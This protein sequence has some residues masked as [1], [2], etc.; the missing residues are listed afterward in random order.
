MP[1]GTPC[2]WSATIG[3]WEKVSGGK[4]S[5]CTLLSSVQLRDAEDHHGYF[6][7]KASAIVVRLTLNINKMHP[8]LLLWWIGI[9]SA[10]QLKSLDG[11]CAQGWRCKRQQQCRPFQDLR[12]RLKM[13]KDVYAQGRDESVRVQY[14]N[15]LEEAKELVCNKA[16]KGVCCKESFEVVNGNVVQKVEDVP[17]MA[18]ISIKTGFASYASCGASLISS[19]FLLTAKHCLTAFDDECIA[20]KDCVAH[21]RDLKTGR[22]NHEPGQFFI[23]ITK[24]FYKE[25]IGSDLAVIKL[26]NKVEEHP[27]YSNGAALSPIRLATENPNIGDKCLTAGWGLTGYNEE[28]SVE[29]RSLEL[30]VTSAVD[31]WVYTSNFDDEGR[32]TDTCK[33]DSGGPLAIWRDGVWELV[34]VL[35]GEGYDCR[36]NTTN[37]DGQWS[38]VAVQRTWVFNQIYGRA[39]G[40]IHLRGTTG[41][42]RPVGA[43]IAKGNVYID[44]QPI[45]D[46]G[47]GQEEAE[48]ACRML[49]YANGIPEKASTYG[50][51]NRDE[52]FWRSDLQCMGD[53]ESL[54][55]CPGRDNPSCAP[56]EVAG[57]TCGNNILLSFVRHHL[58]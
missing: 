38:S 17:Y 25:G 45:C 11:L 2:G 29:L 55:G 57:V 50:R 54:A 22:T 56:G 1:S 10:Q 51:A 27:E 30:K 14:E 41:Q 36:T 35:K 49:G 3:L 7:N 21:F 33:G 24:V 26:K 6:P 20:E 9:L 43:D 44:D 48:V 42:Q 40:E 13:L 19:Q 23:P 58:S 8:L 39:T 53:E 37:G 12:N 31:I 4:I 52:K 28:A 18:R 15:G 34:G 32:L 5:R 16:R 46:D 47:W